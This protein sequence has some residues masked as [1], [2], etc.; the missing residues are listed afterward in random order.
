MI[1]LNKVRSNGRRSYYNFK[2]P[3]GNIVEAR[4]DSRIKF[5][6][7][8]GCSVSNLRNH[9]ESHTR[10]YKIW[11]GIKGRA[12]HGNHASAKTYVDRGITLCEEWLEFDYFKRWAE[13]NGYTDKLTID[14]IDINGNYCPS[15]C[16]WVT[17]SENTRQQVKDGHSNNRKI[18]VN[19]VPYISIMEAARFISQFTG[20]IPKSIAAAI[21]T[22]LKENSQE[23]Y[24]GF[25]ITE[26]RR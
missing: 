22:R 21:N 10:L 16:R 13:S 19:G 11:D 4:S 14:R 26:L 15:N 18:L 5:C 7:Q 3:C 23:P 1:K 17:R 24:K 9:G 20:K 8:V 6:R 25:V 2:C 12:L